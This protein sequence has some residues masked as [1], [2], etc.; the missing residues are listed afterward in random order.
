MKQHKADIV[1]IANAIFLLI[2][3]FFVI[4]YENKPDEWELKRIYSGVSSRDMYVDLPEIE[5]PRPPK[6]KVDRQGGTFKPYYVTYK[7]LRLTNIGTYF[8]TAYCPAE[9]GGS[10]MTASGA[11]CHRADDEHRL[12]QPTT[13]AIDKNY[14]SFGQTFYIPEFDRTFI[15]EDTGAF[16][17]KWVDLFYIEY[18]DV[19]AFPTGKYT[20]YTVEWVEKTRLVSEEDNEALQTMSPTDYYRDIVYE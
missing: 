17:G 20:L 7:Q 12:S 10:W 15:S 6:I 3:E 9:C 11:T 16:R 18:S 14:N 13:L 1:L 19:L 8:V 5:R 2:L 4:A